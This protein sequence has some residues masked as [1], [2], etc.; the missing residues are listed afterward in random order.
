[1]NSALAALVIAKTHRQPIPAEPAGD[2]AVAVRQFDAVAM[3]AGFNLSRGLMG[4]PPALDA[5]PVTHRAARVPDVARRE[6]GDPMG[7]GNAV[8]SVRFGGPDK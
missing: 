4:R 6:A 8:G 1:M 2:A 5:G 7:P 3:S